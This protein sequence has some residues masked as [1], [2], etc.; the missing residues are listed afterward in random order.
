MLE[1][2]SSSQISPKSRKV[3]ILLGFHENPGSYRKL[4][5]SELLLQ[6]HPLHSAEVADVR[7]KRIDRTTTEN[8]LCDLCRDPSSLR[9]T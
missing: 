3:Q 6:Q 5:N 1:E 8:I 7:V 4:I 9:S 2:A